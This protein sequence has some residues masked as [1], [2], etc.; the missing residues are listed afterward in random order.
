MIDYKIIISILLLKTT[1]SSPSFCVSKVKNLCQGPFV[2][3]LL[4]LIISHE[5]LKYLSLVMIFQLLDMNGKRLQTNSK[6]LLV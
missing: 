4:K 1:P 2:I 6:R 3:F 5:I